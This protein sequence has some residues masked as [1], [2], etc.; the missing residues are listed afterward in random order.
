MK[1]LL[2]IPESIEIEKHN[3]FIKG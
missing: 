2:N 1:V 3:I